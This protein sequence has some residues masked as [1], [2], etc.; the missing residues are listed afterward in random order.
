MIEVLNVAVPMYLGL[1]IIAGGS[2]ML[3]TYEEWPAI[4]EDHGIYMVPLMAIVFVIFVLCW[5]YS[6]WKF[7]KAWK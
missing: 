6:W 2:V 7:I 3:L 5:P 4:I 1:G